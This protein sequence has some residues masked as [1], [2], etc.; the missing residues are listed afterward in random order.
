MPK[1]D[2]KWDDDDKL[3]KYLKNSGLAS[4]YK[5]NSLS[6][7][8]EEKYLGT[9]CET[10]IQKCKITVDEEGTKAAAVTAMMA[11]CTSVRVKPDNYKE[12]HLDRPFAYMIKDN[13]TG[14][15]LFVGKVVNP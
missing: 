14:Q 12:V 6:D 3:D 8:F 2:Y 10:V 9:T 15:I 11:K 4:L 13:K 5:A 1:F 7:I